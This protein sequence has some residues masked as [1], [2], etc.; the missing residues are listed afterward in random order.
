MSSSSST[1]C[2]ELS[3]C[4]HVSQSLP[5]RKISVPAV[6]SHFAS[7]YSPS[8]ARHRTGNTSASPRPSRAPSSEWQPSMNPSLSTAIGGLGFPLGSVPGH[9]T[10]KP[11]V[12]ER[13]EGK[14][15]RS[16][17]RRDGIAEQESREKHRAHAQHDG[18]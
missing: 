1:C 15:H 2:G 5:Q 18:V 16:T 3:P 7:G 14:A 11:G 4:L 10:Q 9:A 6:T 17:D 12:N 8:I 13:D